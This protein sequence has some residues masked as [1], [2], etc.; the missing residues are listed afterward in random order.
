MDTVRTMEASEVASGS[1]YLTLQNLLTNL[2]GVFGL[3]YLARAITQE[4]MGMLTA[5]TL[6]NSFIPLVSDFGLA[7]SLPKFVSELKGRGEDVSTHILAT[8]IFKIPVTLLPCLALY[9]FSADVSSILFGV[10]DK[11]D[12]VRLAVIDAFILAFVSVLSS[13]LLGAGR[14]KRIAISSIFSITT[15]WLVIVLLLMSGYGFYGT[16]IGWIVGDLILLVLYAAISIRLL[17]HGETLFRHS[18][19]LIPR[20]LKFSWPL[21]AASIVSFIYAWYDRAIIL[22]FLPLTDLG[23]YDVSYKAFTVLASLAAALGAA[24]YPFYGMAYGKKDHEAIASGIKRATRYTAIIVFPLTL[25]LLST[26]NAVIT[27]FAGQQYESGWSILAILAVFG[28]VY[29]LL[30]AFTG[31]FVIYEKTKTVFL[32]SLVPVLSSLGLFPLLWVSG[33]NGLAAM[34]GVSLLV[35]LLLTMFFLS[36]IVRIKIDKKAMFKALISS[37]IMAVVVLAVQ[38]VRYSIILFPVYVFIGAA[39]YIGCIRILKVFNESDIQLLEQ[40]IGKGKTA[41]LAKVLGYKK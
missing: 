28:L 5:L 32:L 1:I 4:Q 36:K 3:T 11:F 27:L 30:P 10:A 2:I 34:R 21:F 29:G 17:K 8:L 41:I 33:L 15:K 38:Q 9:I 35:T 25:G 22:A 39:V 14:M 31:L 20:I 12:L 23:I 18:I 7:S 37:I 26:A 16:V 19:S 13:I 40:I 24:L 6:V